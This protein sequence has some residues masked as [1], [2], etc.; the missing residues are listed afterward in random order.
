MSQSTQQL[1]AASQPGTTVTPQSET[2]IMS[3]AERNSLYSEGKAHGYV[4]GYL[5]G[6]NYGYDEGYTQGKMHGYMEGHYKGTM[7]SQVSHCLAD[8]RQK[9]TAR[10]PPLTNE[11]RQDTTLPTS[12]NGTKAM[13]AGT[14]GEGRVPMMGRR[15][16]RGRREVQLTIA[17]LS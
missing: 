13:R 10:S 7:N 5:H 12:L 9:N 2:Y 4:E 11:T 14:R 17:N 6:K 3:E 1:A 16:N 15:S 8:T